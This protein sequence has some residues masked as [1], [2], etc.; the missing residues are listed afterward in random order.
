M[1]FSL[2]LVVLVGLP[3]IIPRFSASVILK[4]ITGIIRYIWRN[5]RVIC[6]FMCNDTFSDDISKDN[7]CNHFGVSIPRSQPLAEDIQKQKAKDGHR[8][9]CHSPLL[10]V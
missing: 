5:C 1:F 10:C 6:D 3:S 9:N 8:N 4:T 7:N 2:F